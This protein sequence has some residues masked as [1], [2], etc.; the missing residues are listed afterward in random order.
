ML[1]CFLF[2]IFQYLESNLLL[3]VGRSTF[4]FF[5]SID[6]TNLQTMLVICSRAPQIMHKYTFKWYVISV[7]RQK[8]LKNVVIL[9]KRQFSENGAAT[10]WPISLKHH[11]FELI[12]SLFLYRFKTKHNIA[13]CEQ[14]A[15]LK[16]NQNMHGQI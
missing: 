10:R 11:R 3:T 9:L 13:V 4:F 6:S 7:C 14:Y 12:L 8:C 2:N 5:C 15:G 16:A 1:E